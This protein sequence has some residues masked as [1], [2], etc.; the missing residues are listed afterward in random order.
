MLRELLPMV[1]IDFQVVTRQ[2][3][4]N[5]QKTGSRNVQSGSQIA[6]AA[7][8]AAFAI[9]SIIDFFQFIDFQLYLFRAGFSDHIFIFHQ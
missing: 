4:A 6:K 1:S 8:R 5:F 2:A 3:I 7:L 9:C